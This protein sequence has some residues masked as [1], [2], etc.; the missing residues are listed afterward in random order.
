MNKKG[1]VVLL[2]FDETLRWSLKNLFNGDFYYAHICCVF[3]SG[4][5]E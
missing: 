1:F 3:E 2:Y 4:F 5:S